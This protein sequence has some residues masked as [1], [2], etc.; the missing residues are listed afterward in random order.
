MQK[1]EMLTPGRIFG[2]RSGGD[3]HQKKIAD[4]YEEYEKQLRANNAL[5]F[6][7]LL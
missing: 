3:F 7:D 5:D 1:S 4:V 6:D 2:F